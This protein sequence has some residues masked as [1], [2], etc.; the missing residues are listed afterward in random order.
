MKKAT[1][2]FQ[3]AR[4]NVHVTPSRPALTSQSASPKVPVRAKAVSDRA[5]ELGQDRFMVRDDY[6]RLLG[7]A[8]V[9][10]V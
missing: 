10:M 7:P 2:R 8:S 4:S 3:S 9:Y 6:L 1:R 5:S